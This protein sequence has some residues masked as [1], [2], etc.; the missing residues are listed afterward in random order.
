M[1]KIIE[2]LYNNDK[3]TI[4]ELI[5]ELK[6]IFPLL[7]RYEDTEQDEVWHAEGNV[8]IHTELVLDEVYKIIDTHKLSKDDKV[9]L[10]LSALLH[11]I[12]KPSTTVSEFSERENRIC[13]KAPKHEIIGRD[14]LSYRLL[15]LGINEYVYKN[16]LSLVAYH[17]VPKMLVI[18]NKDKSDYIHHMQMVNYNLMYHLECADIKG[19]ICNDTD[20]QLSYLDEYKMFCDEYD[21]NT[22]DSYNDVVGTYLLSR[23]ELYSLDEAEH[24]LW[25][26]KKHSRVTILCGIPGSGKSSVAIGNIISLDSIRKEIGDKNH[27]RSS[28][29]INIAK[30]R[31]KEYLRNK[32]DV[33]YDAT[34]Y[35]KDFRQK[36]FDLCHAYHADVTLHM[37]LK[38]LKQCLI[39]NR[40][41]GDKQ[42]DDAY[43]IHQS[44]RFE[45]PE[46]GE[47]HRLKIDIR[48]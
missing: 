13:V 35:R 29:V 24:K 23:N 15:D 31:L 33:T 26:H 5:N 36:L 41:R 3:P 7:L 22:S 9:I 42:V 20:S 21:L 47:Y 28:E 8:L 25:D 10:I 11:D 14:Y 32:E 16:V 40:C 39:D 6:F 38:P 34:N 46:Y 18:R 17:Q 2:Q 48:Y 19:R 30:E 44:N 1:L 12:A 27:K 4:H 37:I 43:I 45:F